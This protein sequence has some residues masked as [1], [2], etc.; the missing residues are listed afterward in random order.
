MYYKYSNDFCVGCIHWKFTQKVVLP[1][2][3]IEEGGVLMGNFSSRR[4]KTTINF[5]G[6]FVLLIVV[7]ERSII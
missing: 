1:R 7:V 5:V 2:L 4:F 3:D 6:Y